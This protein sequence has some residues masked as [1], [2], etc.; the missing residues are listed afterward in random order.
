MGPS[1]L[2]RLWLAIKPPPAVP[3]RDIEPTER[4]I[5]QELVKALKPPPPLNP[6]SAEELRKRRRLLAVSTSIVLVGGIGW[7]TYLY[8]KSAP[9][10]AESAYQEGMHLMASANYKV[11][12]DRFTQAIQIWPQLADAYYERGLALQNLH[13]TE[14]AL[15]D[16]ERAVN[17]NPSLAPA[18]VAIGSIYS[19]RGNPD[20]AMNEFNLAINVESNVEAYYQRGQAYETRG[21]YQKAIEDYNTAIAMRPDAPYVYGARASARAKLGDAAGATRD[22]QKS[23][24]LELHGFAK[25]EG[26]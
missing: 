21:E 12:A 3:Y 10:R 6:I 22:R 9:Q 23:R 18:H 8:I 24:E 25:P 20:R 17:T 26:P 14:A 2:K 5:F 15:K 11:A 13:D 19:L 1:R 7:G 16:F 4:S